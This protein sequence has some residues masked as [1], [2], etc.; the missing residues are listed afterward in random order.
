[1]VEEEGQKEEKFDFDSAGEAGGYISLE[2][3]RVLAIE[4][5]RDNTDFYGPRYRNRRLVWEA[6][7]ADEGEDFYEVRL[8]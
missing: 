1:M 8:S 7:S 4:H 5:A 2:Q 6:V 3:A